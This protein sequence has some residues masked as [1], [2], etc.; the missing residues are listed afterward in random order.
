MVTMATKHVKTLVPRVWNL[1]LAPI[2]ES[3]LSSLQV[4]NAAET[5]VVQPRSSVL[6]KNMSIFRDCWVEDVNLLTRS[7]DAIAPLL[8]FL[9]V[10]GWG[11]EGKEKREGR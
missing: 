5:L 2:L 3:N 11:R 10:T 8:D 6:Q 7:L 1:K 4:V 9:I